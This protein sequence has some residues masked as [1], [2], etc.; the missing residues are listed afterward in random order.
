MYHIRQQSRI[1]SEVEPFSDDFQV[2]FAIT[3][4]TDLSLSFVDG[5]VLLAG[6]IEH[7]GSVT[8]DVLPPEVTVD[9]EGDDLSAGTIVTDQ[10]ADVGLTISTPS[11]FGAMLFD[12]NNPTGGDCDLAA[13]DLG[14]VAIISEDGDT[15]DPDDNA[16]GGILTFEWDTL[17]GVTGVGLLDIDEPGGSITFFDENSNVIETVEIPELENNSFQELEFDVQNVARMDIS[18]TASGAVTAVDFIPSDNLDA[19]AAPTDALVA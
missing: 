4:E 1:D 13:S 16:N 6:T 7:E 17:V 9:F 12:T 11:E 2:G 5:L 18:F 8:F 19:I 14:N 10:F 15:T 3:D